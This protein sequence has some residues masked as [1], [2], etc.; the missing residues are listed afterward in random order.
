MGRVSRP[1]V[2]GP[3]VSAKST[4][5]S[6]PSRERE[7]TKARGVV[8]NWAAYDEL[9]RTGHFEEGLEPARHRFLCAHERVP[10]GM[11]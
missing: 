4:R 1:F 9:V 11:I 5:I 2:L 7:R 3:G 8:E 10:E 6:N